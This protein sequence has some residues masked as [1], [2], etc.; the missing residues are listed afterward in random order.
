MPSWRASTASFATN[1]STRTTSQSL[2]K[3]VQSSK[4]G[5][6]T[7][8]RRGRISRSAIA[9][10]RSPSKI[11]STCNLR[12]YSWDNTWAQVIGHIIFE[13]PRW[14]SPQSLSMRTGMVRQI[15]T[16]LQNRC[17]QIAGDGDARKSA[18]SGQ[19]QI[20]L[21]RRNNASGSR[22]PG[23]HGLLL[24]GPPSRSGAGRRALS[25]PQTTLIAP[26]TSACSR[27]GSRS[28]CRPPHPNRC[29][30][31][32]RRIAGSDK[33]PSSCNR[34]ILARFLYGRPFLS[35]A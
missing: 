4:P 10:P 18:K 8:T 33:A 12:P 28:H 30:R 13:E 29:S 21:E 1:A 32:A 26:C 20:R 16:S 34:A 24:G 5:A 25:T 2:R 11:F 31:N 22:R 14:W 23:C 35:T 19:R 17:D 15:V 6:W 7:T 3:P 27:S 9:L